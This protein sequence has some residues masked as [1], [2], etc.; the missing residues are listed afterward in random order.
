MSLQTT[1]EIPYNLR[2]LTIY[3]SK[4][5]KTCY[6]GSFEFVLSGI[7]RLYSFPFLN[8]ALI[9]PRALLYEINLKSSITGSKMASYGVEGS[10]A[11][12]VSY[13]I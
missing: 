12:L 1:L 7:S 6:V 2:Y 13:P 4:H 11:H 8:R 5:N 9:A 10:V 3:I